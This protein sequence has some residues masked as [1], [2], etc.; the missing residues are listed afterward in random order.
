[1]DPKLLRRTVLVVFVGGIALAVGMLVDNAVVVLESVVRRRES[2]LDRREAARLGTADVATAVFAATL[3][4]VAVFLAA[5]EETKIHAA[6]R[7]RRD[8]L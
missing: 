7:R 2:G 3:T 8:V 6:A 4:S 1:M 5:L